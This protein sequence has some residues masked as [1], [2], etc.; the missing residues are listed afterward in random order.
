MSLGVGEAPFLRSETLQGLVEINQSSQYEQ[1][2]PIQQ[3]FGEPELVESETI[4][5]EADADNLLQGTLHAAI[6]NPDPIESTQAG[7]KKVATLYQQYSY[8]IPPSKY[9][10]MRLPGDPFQG[11][12]PG[13]S[14][15]IIGVMRNRAEREAA[16]QVLRMQ[17]RIN[18]TWEQW[19]ADYLALASGWSLSVGGV[20]QTVSPGINVVVSTASWETASTDIQADLGRFLFEFIK[21]AGG[22]PTDMIYSFQLIPEFADNTTIRD[23]LN[24][25]MGR[26]PI[27]ALPLALLPPEM[28]NINILQS[29]GQFNPAAGATSTRSFVWPKLTMTW[30][31]RLPGVLRRIWAPSARNQW[32]AVGPMVAWSHAD[33]MNFNTYLNVGANGA[34]FVANE[35]QVMQFDLSGP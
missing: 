6:A 33:P 34:P 10:A 17:N 22:P 8:L 35:D 20:S 32:G 16:K 12:Q 3:L 7:Q 13:N 4:I 27:T 18:R 21:Q 1:D 11:A 25:V 31:R 19:A 5:V 28:Q 26:G 30:I 14:A 23:T 9:A 2:F 29:Q 24:P 15:G